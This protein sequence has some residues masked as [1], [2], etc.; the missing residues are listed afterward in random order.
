MELDKGK[1]KDQGGE[2][3]IEGKEKQVTR[4]KDDS[5]RSK[6]EGGKASCEKRQ[7]K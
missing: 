3:G 6:G 1:G 2:K 4:G 5:G 7:D